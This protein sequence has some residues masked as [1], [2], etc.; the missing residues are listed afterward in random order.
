MTTCLILLS[1]FI[2]FSLKN[3]CKV[4]F[5]FYSLKIAFSVA[6]P[7]GGHFSRVERTL[8]GQGKALEC[9]RG[10]GWGWVLG[11]GGR[12]YIQQMAQFSG[13]RFRCS[14]RASE[15]KNRPTTAHTH[16]YL[17]TSELGQSIK[18]AAPLAADMRRQ[19]GRGRGVAP[20]ELSSLPAAG[21]GACCG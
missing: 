5:K 15:I 12:K 1:I 20:K 21:R 14:Q 10:V 8:K 4:S 18:E 16:T 2:Y 3:P 11:E 7:L 9:A 13:R 6:P 17:Y 19:R